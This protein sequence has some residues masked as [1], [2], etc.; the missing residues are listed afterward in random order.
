M[1][2]GIH[3]RALALLESRLV[4]DLERS[5]RYRSLQIQPTGK[6]LQMDTWKPGDRMLSM[7]NFVKLSWRGG[8]SPS[9][10]SVDRSKASLEESFLEK[11]MD[12]VNR[13]TER[14]GS[15]VNSIATIPWAA[16]AE[17]ERQELMLRASTLS[18]GAAVRPLDPTVLGDAGLVLAACPKISWL[19]GWRAS[20]GDNYSRRLQPLASQ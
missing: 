12:I 19:A 15:A 3:D 7:G 9:G 18:S 4:E 17:R 10:P 6:V 20:V 5:G 1:T 13:Q 16:L 2:T 11:H 8:M 14:H